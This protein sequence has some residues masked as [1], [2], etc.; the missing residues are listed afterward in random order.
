VPLNLT[1]ELQRKH[2]MWCIIPTY[3]AFQTHASRRQ[4]PSLA[5]PNREAVIP[6]AS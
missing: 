4:N 3:E 5:P 1:M 6:G 2:N